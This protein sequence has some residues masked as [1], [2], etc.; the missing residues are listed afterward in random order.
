[1]THILKCKYSRKFFETAGIVID[2]NES[3]HN[4]VTL[5]N[6]HTSESLSLEAVSDLSIAAGI[7]GTEVL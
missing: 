4:V 7:P 3:S 2:K 1:M 5:H 6:I